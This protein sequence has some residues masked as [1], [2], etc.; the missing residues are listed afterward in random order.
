MGASPD[1][2]T[3]WH[4]IDWRQCQSIVRKL[5]ARIVKATQEKRW[6][7]VRSLQRLL[8]CSFSG[9]AMAVRRVT[10]NKGKKTPG[11]DMVTWSTP[12][13]KSQAILELKKRGYKTQ[14]L[15]RVYIPKKNGK[16]RPLGIPTMK[17]RAM[18]ALYA[19]AL[20]PVAETTADHHSYGFR[21]ERSTMDAIQQCFNALSLKCAA[22][23]VLEADIEGCFDNISHDWMLKHI[24]MD[25]LILQKWLKAG[26]IDSNKFYM[27]ESGSPQGGVISPLLANLVLD[28]LGSMLREKYF[29]N[30]SHRKP[31]HTVNFIRYA[32]DFV[33]TGRSKELLENEIK[34]LVE[35]F[36]EERGLRLSQEKTKVTHID[37]GFDF[38]GQTIRKYDGKLLITPSK[39]SVKAFLKKIRELI[40]RHKMIEQEHLIAL[41]NPLIRGW[42]NYH[43][44]VVSSKTFSKVHS[45]IWKALWKWCKR[46][47]S[48]KS[49]RWIRNK[50]FRTIGGNNWVF[51]CNKTKEG[52]KI[53]QLAILENPTRTP[54]KRHIKVRAE[55]NPFDRQWDAYIEK[56]IKQKMYTSLSGYKKWRS[57]WIEQDGK[58][59]VCKESITLARGWD[60]HHI[61]ERSKGGDNQN[62]NLI[63]LHPNCHRQAHS[64]KLQLVK[65]ASAC[66]S[67]KRLEPD[68]GKLSR[69]V[70]RGREEQQ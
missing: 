68:D 17:E 53:S 60:I 3:E 20:E 58:C 44:F 70:L 48:K 6:N 43:R 22:P 36:L 47:H 51:A 30:R 55:L 7:K 24:P 62:S 23:W 10:E 13:S 46:R 69:P 45:E 31:T 4:Q 8:T 66:R 1:K 38:L 41:L 35:A 12:D 57:L 11:V 18:Q 9:K 39:S 54:I 2:T 63:L 42:V 65:P 52:K 28:G 19:L 16:L 25:K 59:L 5:Q 27:T 21:P 34:P 64:L 40:K 50:Y 32:D 56:R 29:T 14:P 33:I 61:Q 37:E 67:L 26:Y 15:R 49:S